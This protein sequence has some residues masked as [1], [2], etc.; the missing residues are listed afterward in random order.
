MVKGSSATRETSPRPTP[1]DSSVPTKKSRLG[2][3]RG[4]VATPKK[5]PVPSPKEQSSASV[6]VGT[7]VLVTSGD[8]SQS[9]NTIPS[10]A[11]PLSAD[12]AGSHGAT[13]AKVLR[14]GG[15]YDCIVY[16][17]HADSLCL[18]CCVCVVG[19]V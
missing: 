14:A 1:T 5:T 7:D 12:A 15:G 11:T 3:G 18:G 8:N 4:L 2:W 9:L 16:S 17:L 6:A 19:V 10:S 13:K